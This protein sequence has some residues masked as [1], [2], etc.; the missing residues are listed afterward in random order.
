M[1]S[2]F[3]DFFF[4]RFK[5][6]DMEAMEQKLKEFKIKYIKRTVGDEGAEA[7]DQLFFN[8]PDGFMI[9]IC[10]CENMKLVPQR[11]IGRIKL[12]SDSHNP[13][14]QLD[15]NDARAANILLQHDKN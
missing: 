8:D 10:N 6:E 15:L 4:W 3:S 13:P 2:Y 1:L 14:L 7:I 12:P 11:S 9:E 5:C